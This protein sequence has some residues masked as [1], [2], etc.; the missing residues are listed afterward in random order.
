MRTLFQAA[1]FVTA[2]MV[3]TVV[4]E[5]AESRANH[6]YGINADPVWDFKVADPKASELPQ[7]VAMLRQSK[8]GAVRVPIRWRVVEPRRGEWDFSAIDRVV[9]AVSPEIEILAVLMSVPEWAN[10]KVP[11]KVEGWFDAYP[12]RDFADWERAVS[13]IVGRYRE[14]IKHWEIWNEP[15]GVDFYRPHPDARMYTELLKISH[16]AAK[17]A[18]PQ[19]VV[20]LGGLQ[21]NGI[22]A[23]LWSPVKV[24]NFLEELYKAGAG[25]FFDVCNTHPYVL[26]EEGAARMMA[27]T[28][29]TLAVMARHGDATK[30]LWLTEVG[31]GATSPAAESA[32]ARLLAETFA[33]ARAEPQI[34][35]VFWFTLRD[36]EKDLLG[37]ESSM[38]L[39]RYNG[40]RKPALEAFVDAAARGAGA[41]GR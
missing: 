38:G 29:D 40:E 6:F 28:R 15:N 12:P 37:P 11:G 36:M 7:F 32:Q 21:M 25:P 8:C 41:S 5:S 31:C 27:L 19:C 4:S 1:R 9:A 16:R 22:I 10:G 24:P 20:V 3:L 34:R 39:F 30:P 13:K 23:N 2:A 17:Q 33:L 26:P 14:R 35:R 18:D